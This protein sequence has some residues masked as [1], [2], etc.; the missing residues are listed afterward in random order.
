M[1]NELTEGSSCSSCAN[2]FGIVGSVNKNLVTNQKFFRYRLINDLEKRKITVPNMLVP[3]RVD[4]SRQRRVS[5]FQ[6]R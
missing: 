1:L 6:D 5:L 3:V 4:I 2:S